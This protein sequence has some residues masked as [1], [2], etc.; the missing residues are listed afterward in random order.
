MERPIAMVIGQENCFCALE[1][2]KLQSEIF[3]DNTIY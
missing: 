1:A 2:I 3:T